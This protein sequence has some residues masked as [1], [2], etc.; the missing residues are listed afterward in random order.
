MIPEPELKKLALGRLRDARALYNAGRYDAAVYMVGYS[1]EMA[2]KARICRTLRWD[3]FPEK[4]KEFEGFQ[5]LKTHRLDHLLKLSG[6]ET[7]IKKRYLFAWIE[8]YEWHPG[9]RYNPIGTTV[10][11]TARAMIAAVQILMRAL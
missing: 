1:V 2:L 3:A 6:Q 11:Q 8:V 10:P 7:R 4:A 5:S 9:F